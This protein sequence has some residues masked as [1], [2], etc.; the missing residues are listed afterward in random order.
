[1]A[2][3]D[4]IRFQQVYGFGS[5][6]A[7]KALEKWHSPTLLFHTEE[8]LLRQHGM[9]E[10][11]CRRITEAAKTD[12]SPILSFCEK[13]KV[14]ILTPEDDLYPDRL[15]HIYSPPAVLYVAGNWENIDE[16]LTIAVVGTRRCTEYGSR[17]ARQI[18][19]DL[20]ARGVITVSGL[21]KGIDSCCHDATVQAGGRTIAVQGCGIDVTYPAANRGLKRKI[22]ENGGAVISEFPPGAEPNAYHFPI[23]NRII[24]GLSHGTLVVEGEQQ[25]GSL[26]TAGFALTEGR[27]VFAVPGNVDS[28]MSQAP[29]WLIREGAVMA[30]D[31]GDI[32]AEYD[33]AEYRATGP[34]DAALP[35]QMPLE[36]GERFGQPRQSGG[37]ARKSPAPGAASVRGADLML[38]HLNQNQR[39]LLGVMSSQPQTADELVAQ[40]GLS[41]PEVLSVLTQ[42][43]IFGI[44]K[45]HAGHR[46]SR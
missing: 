1:M 16:I 20:A 15:R 26:I 19:A 35:E 45:I 13:N 38:E 34:A 23:R 7:A 28:A 32:L 44:I 9:K 3:A 11:E 8:R 6:R 27:D 39:I 42:L 30:R 40:S 25:S 43:E 33:L 22:L 41:V 10:E 36:T 29:N 14:R 4:W 46:F 24:A 21:A 31:A 12:V 5:V 17:T 37:A 2:V 18:S